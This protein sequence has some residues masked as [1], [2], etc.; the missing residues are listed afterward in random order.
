MPTKDIKTNFVGIDESQIPPHDPTN[1]RI[2]NFAVQILYN[3]ILALAKSSVLIFL[4]RLF[5]QKGGVRKFIIC[6]NTFN[7]LHMFGVF[8]ALTFQCS[9]VAFAWDKT[10]RGGQCVEQRVLFTSN[11]VINI[12]VDFLILGLP[13]WIFV[14]LKIPKRA[15]VG[16]MFVFLLGFL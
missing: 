7:I 13:L 9:P 4:L 5:G 15:K 12:I 1:G 16:L 10:I 14:D 11:A 2:W 8:F 3:P 6:L